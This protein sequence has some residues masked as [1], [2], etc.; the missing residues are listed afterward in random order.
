M[1]VDHT[2]NS[3][4]D[5]RDILDDLKSQTDRQYYIGTGVCPLGRDM[6][7]YLDDYFKTPANVTQVTE[8][9][10]KYMSISLFE[11]LGGT[12]PSN[13]IDIVPTRN[14]GELR[15]QFRDKES[16]EDLGE[17]PIIIQ[18]PQRMPGSFTGAT[19][20]TYGRDW[21]ITKISNFYFNEGTGYDENNKLFD[22]KV[23][24][25]V[26]QNSEDTSYKEIILNV[27]T[28]AR[29][30]KCSL[31]VANGIGQFLVASGAD[32]EPS[33]KKPIDFEDGILRLIHSLEDKDEIN[34]EVNLGENSAYIRGFLPS[35]FN[36][37]SPTWKADGK[38]IHHR[39]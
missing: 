16:S 20:D 28:Q 33:C 13:G 30:G 5:P 24:A 22:F 14:E 10:S 38:H 2:Y 19:W 3:G 35:F 18:L 23:L 12:Y 11:D 25:R 39:K 9:D 21:V 31:T 8:Y 29:V 34:T 4:A 32:T 7:L 26:Q 15:I 37:A 27:T 6:E 36:D 1:P 17:N